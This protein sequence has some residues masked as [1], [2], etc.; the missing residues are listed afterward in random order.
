MVHP[1]LMRRKIRTQKSRMLFG[2]EAQKNVPGGQHDPAQEHEF[3]ARF[4]AAP[5]AF[6]HDL[7]K[8]AKVNL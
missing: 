7:L 1:W 2:Q 5:V 8:P 4:A 6:L 3:L